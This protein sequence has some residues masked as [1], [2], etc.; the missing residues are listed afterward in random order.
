VIQNPG[1]AA[2][3]IAA[4]AGDSSVLPGLLGKYRATQDFP[5]ALLWR[6][7]TELYPHAR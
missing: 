7:M 6:E 3:W 1:T 4:L 5:G 2:G